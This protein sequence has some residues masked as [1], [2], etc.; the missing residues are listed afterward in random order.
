M[1]RNLAGLLRENS[2]EAEECMD[3]IKQ[4]LGGASHREQVGL[5]EE[6]IGVLDFASAQRTLAA[7]AGVR[8]G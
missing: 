7:I 8:W 2:L 5:L 4:Y 3:V 6:Q 1:L